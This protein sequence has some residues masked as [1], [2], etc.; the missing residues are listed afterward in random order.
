MRIGI[1]CRTML[2][3]EGG[4]RAGVGHYTH[5]LVHALVPLTKKDQLVLFFD[6][7]MPHND[8][9]KN[10]AAQSHVKIVRFPFSQYK[11]Y[12]PFGYSHIVVAETLR[13]HHL[14]VFHS[15]AYIIP[16]QYRKP[17]V[18]TIHDLA[19][20]RH[21]EWFPPKQK[22]STSF[23]VPSSVKRASK[24][25]AVSRATSKMVQDSFGVASRDIAVIYEGMP[26]AR[27]LSKAKRQQTLNTFSIHQRFFFYIGTIEPR[28]NLESLVKAFDQFLESH[29]RHRDIQLVLAGNKGWK[30]DRIFRSIARARWSMNIRYL[31]YIS[32]EEKTALM[33]SC[34]AFTFPSLWEGFGLPVLEA[35]AMGVPVL[36]S[37]VS[38]LPEVA[39]DGALYVNPRSIPSIQRGLS[40]LA[41]DGRKRISLG[42]KGKEH[43]KQFSWERCAKETYGIYRQIAH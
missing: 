13:T 3:P 16:Y 40:T 8:M 32:A 23:L 2:N 5:A 14:D 21:P 10:L 4:E 24:I 1:D 19:I 37:K 6:H 18:I 26:K 35:A 15:P 25:I 30:H 31:G 41:S 11:R 39:G 7:R 20:Y 33:Q 27:P 36:T 22:F 28:K 12:L 9:M 43:A 17:S 29:P 34:M 42:K 38:S